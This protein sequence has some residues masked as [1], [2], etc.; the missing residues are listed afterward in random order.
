VI[1]GPHL[2]RPSGYCI[3]LIL[4]MSQSGKS[5]LSETGASKTAAS[6]ILS[7]G[8]TIEKPQARESRRVLELPIENPRVYGSNETQHNSTAT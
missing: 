4:T 3:L 1:A 8:I 6:I 7:S 5:R 2:N